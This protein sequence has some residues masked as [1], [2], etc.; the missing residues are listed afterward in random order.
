MR[1]ET[2]RFKGWFG[3]LLIVAKTEANCRQEKVAL[4]SN[5][6]HLIVATSNCRR[7]EWVILG[8]SQASSTWILIS[9]QKKD[10]H[11]SNTLSQHFSLLE[12]ITETIT[13]LI[14]AKKL[15]PRKSWA[16]FREVAR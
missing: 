6:R 12:T 16:M 8:V 15:S 14:V 13:F 2:G 3:P 9:D 5:C 10:E 4:R 7:P 1:T 11:G